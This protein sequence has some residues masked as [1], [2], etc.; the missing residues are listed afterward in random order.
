[1]LLII[2]LGIEIFSINKIESLLHYL[3]LNNN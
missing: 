3:L 1:M 2:I